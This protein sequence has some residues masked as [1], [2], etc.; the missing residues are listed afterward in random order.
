MDVLIFSKEIKEIQVLTLDIKMEVSNW[1][2]I[3][4]TSRKEIISEKY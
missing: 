1:N 4:N 2:K 3:K